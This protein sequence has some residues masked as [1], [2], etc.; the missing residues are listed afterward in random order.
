MKLFVSFALLLSVFFSMSGFTTVNPPVHKSAKKSPPWPITGT[1]FYPYSISGG[2]NSPSAITFTVDD[3]TTI[4]YYF[5]Q[6]IGTTQW[7]CDIPTNSPVYGRIRIVKLGIFTNS[8]AYTL[9]F[10][11]DF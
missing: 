1:H 4:N 11:P 10:L 5:Y 2:G 8:N 6:P 3:V 9:E 7:E